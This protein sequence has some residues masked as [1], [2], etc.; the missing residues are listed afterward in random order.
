[1]FPFVLPQVYYCILKDIID[2]YLY[3]SCESERNY[4]F[5][6]LVEFIMQME[7]L[8]NFGCKITS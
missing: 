2:K 5:R 3:V 6:K 7:D 8:D 1:M 4:L